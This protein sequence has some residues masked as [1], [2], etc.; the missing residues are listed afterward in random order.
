MDLAELRA[1][2]TVVEK[3]SF[4]GAASALGVSRTTLRRHVASLEAR[5][6]VPLLET[7][8]HGV[9]A[10]EAGQVLVRQGRTMMEEASALLASIREVGQAPS[11]TMRVVLPVGLPPHVLTPIHAALRAAYPQLHYHLRLSNDPLAESLTD[12]DIAVHFGADPP[13][14][15]WISYVVMRVRQHLVAGK[16][17]LARRGTPKQIDDL[18]HHELMAWQA[19]GEDARIW[20]TWSGV[21]FGV[22]PALIATDIHYLRQCARGGLGIAYVPDALLPDP[23]ALG[24][25]LVPVMASEV[26]QERP[27]RVSVPSALAEIPKVRM[28]IER[29]KAFLGEI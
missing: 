12:V 14:G 6:G 8:R 23:D 18:R 1:F 29:V 10:T 24:D 7:E 9:S 27:V 20:R 16:G 26:G 28:V 17:Y 13:R 22:A 11:G 15:S 2:I 4:L 25:T 3:G 5:A 21:A 19:P